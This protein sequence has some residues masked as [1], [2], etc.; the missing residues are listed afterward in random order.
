MSF[1]ITLYNRTSDSAYV[2]KTLITKGS[3]TYDN[4]RG[5]FDVYEPTFIIQTDGTNPVTILDANA[6][7]Y[8]EENFK[9]DLLSGVINYLSVT[10]NS[11]TRYY[12]IL[13]GD[14]IQN[15]LISIPCHEDVL[16]TFKAKIKACTGI[17]RRNQNEY[18]LYIKDDKIGVYEKPIKRQIVFGAG[19]TNTSLTYILTVASKPPKLVTDVNTIPFTINGIDDSS[20]SNGGAIV[21]LNGC[22]CEYDSHVNKIYWSSFLNNP[23]GDWVIC[24][25]AAIYYD[26][27]PQS[28]S[29][30]YLSDEWC[31]A[32]IVDCE[33]ED[34]KVIN[35]TLAEMGSYQYGVTMN[36]KSHVLGGSQAFRACC[37][38]VGGII[39]PI[40]GYYGTT[41]SINGVTTNANRIRIPSN[42]EPTVLNTTSN[43]LTFGYHA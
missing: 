13:K 1:V 14:Y 36:V 20:A 12:Y 16:M 28:P 32:K 7:Y 33:K 24:P 41:L 2:T 38:S 21:W 37:W 31:I 22:S 26:P 34:G 23:V 8:G 17:I 30:Y 6:Q 35:V 29:D 42:A 11:L 25:K 18:N 27:N 3:I 40:T 10:V 15:N 43:T 4:F 5:E 39:D 19:F 9:A